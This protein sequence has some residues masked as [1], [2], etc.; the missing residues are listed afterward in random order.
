MKVGDIAATYEEPSSL[1]PWKDNPRIT[2]KAI[3]V[4]ARSIERFGFGAPVVAR[5]ANREIIA[6]HARWHAANKLKL[7]AIPVRFLDVNAKTAHRLALVD[8]KSNEL[9][10]WDDVVLRSVIHEVDGKTIAGL[11]F[12]ET[13][14]ARYAQT[15]PSND[16][17]RDD[18]PTPPKKA[19]AKYGDVWEL[20]A[21]RLACCDA[22]HP[23]AV[24][25][26]MDGK[27]ASLFATDP[28]YGVGYNV[29]TSNH[30]RGSIRHSQRGYVQKAHD[31]GT[32]DIDNDA[33]DGPKLQSFLTAVFEAWMP[34]L[35]EHA[36]WY[37]WH[38]QL[39]AGTFA[40]AA[41]RSQ[42]VRIHRQ[43]IWVKGHYVIGRGDFHWQ[44]EVCAYG[45]R[46]SKKGRPPFFGGRDQSTVWNVSYDNGQ[47][48]RN[49]ANREYTCLHP[50]QKP[51]EIFLRSLRCSTAPGDIVIEPFC[52]SGSQIIAA[53][54]LERRCFAMDIL[55]RYVDV[56]IERWQQQT[57]GKAKRIAK[58]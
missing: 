56:T 35:S 36:A 2:K 5:M 53:E 28:P 29:A 32:G 49:G 17:G 4:V 13:E 55:P 20:G 38:A 1:V 40:Q 10:G 6:G 42:G 57:G 27:K 22:T 44:H 11:G 8:N 19:V 23:E 24:A 26:L 47:L 46:P 37:V 33:L 41:M 48:V 18:V 7:A 25:R 16:R 14:I 30:R 15:E 50:T 12:T 21:H 3:E 43:I 51:V 9:A 52:G 34:H 45:W 31:Y 54:E 58:A 39:E